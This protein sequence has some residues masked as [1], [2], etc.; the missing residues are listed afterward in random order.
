[1]TTTCV[2][3]AGGAKTSIAVITLSG[4]PQPISCSTITGPNG[5][6]ILGAEQ[7]TD[8]YGL[9]VTFNTTT[10]NVVAGTPLH[11]TKVSCKPYVSAVKTITAQSGY[12]RVQTLWVGRAQQTSCR[13]DTTKNSCSALV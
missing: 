3:C 5:N 4:S 2:L 7:A 10:V 1:M 8:I 6:Y 11:G 13:Q 9:S 12:H